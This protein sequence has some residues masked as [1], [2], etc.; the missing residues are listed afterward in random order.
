MADFEIPKIPEYPIIPKLE[1]GTMAHSSP[2]VAKPPHQEGLGYP[3]ELVD[4]WENKAIVW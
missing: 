3:T 4:D 2:F 1:E